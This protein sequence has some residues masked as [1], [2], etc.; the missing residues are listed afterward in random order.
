MTFLDL[1]NSLANYSGQNDLTALIPDFVR[2]CESDIRKS[3]RVR[4]LISTTTLT[5]DSESVALPDNFISASSLTLD[6]DEIYLDMLSPERLR[7]SVIAT[8]PAGRPVAYAI[9]GQSVR[10]APAPSISYSGILVYKASYT[11]LSGDTDTNWVLD[12]HYDVYLYGA[13]KHLYIYLEDDDQAQKYQTLFNESVTSINRYENR[14]KYSGST[15]RSTGG[16]VA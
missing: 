5:V 15:F 7:E 2:L 16:S 6:D 11:A 8:Y 13:L 3:L 1:K 9:E 12:N 10:F 14:A 4:D